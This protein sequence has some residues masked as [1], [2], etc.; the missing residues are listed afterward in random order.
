MEVN[1]T[2]NKI[3]NLYG[4]L[5]PLEEHFRQF[6]IGK[7]NW[8]TAD[9]QNYATTKVNPKWLNEALKQDF[10]QRYKEKNNNVI[11]IYGN[12]GAGK[13]LLAIIIGIELGKIY[14]K[15]LNVKN[16]T[17]FDAQFNNALKE[18]ELCD[19]LIH[20]EADEK[21]YGALSTY[22]SGEI[23]DAMFR[24]RALQQNYIFCSPHE[25]ERGQF[26]TIDVK[27][28]RKLNG[29][30]VQIEALLYTSWYNDSETRVCRGVLILDVTKE[31]LDFYDNYIQYKMK[32]LEQ[33]KNDLGGNF[34]IVTNVANKKYEELKNKLIIE[35]NNEY[36]IVK[37]AYFGDIIEV[38]G[39]IG[40]YTR[41]VRQKIIRAI[42]VKAINQVNKL[43][44]GE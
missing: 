43:N 7:A 39:D 9:Y 33:I 5:S 19:T 32:S 30:P 13:S 23:Q 4:K 15:P 12:Q 22:Y 41:D 14:K 34:D 6:D 11:Y 8:T 27:N 42:K 1:K 24:N 18:T 26:I 16:I 36:N 38:D 31:H 17:Y 25:G 3:V 21:T 44:S 40:K 37:G 20:D 10:E 28:T 35:K 29:K 2:M